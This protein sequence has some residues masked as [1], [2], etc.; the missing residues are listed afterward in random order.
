MD[1]PCITIVMPSYNQASYLEEAICSVL[2]QNYPN[3]EFMILDAGSTDGS[4]TIIER[5]AHALSY[6]RSAPDDGQSAAI[7]EG[8]GR[9]TGDLA[10]WLN[11]DDVLLPGSFQVLAQA[12]CEHP[13]AGLFAG[14]LAFIDAQGLIT[15]FLRMPAQAEWFARRG[16]F[17][18]SG[19]GSLFRTADYRAAGGVRHDLH[20][21]MDNELYLRMMLRGTRCA[22]IDRYLAGFRR[23][24][25]QKTSAFKDRVQQ[26][27]MWLDQELRTKYNIPYNSARA[28][29]GYYFWQTLNGN[30]LKKRVHLLSARGRL[31][32]E[33][34]TAVMH[35]GVCQ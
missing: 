29:A 12:Y 26:E 2:D 1:Y 4:R 25:Q 13:T 32:R 28:R 3:L 33:W 34:A 20:Y 15:G 30:Y 18:V 35:A 8:L 21:V 19:P 24:R 9:S 17:A 5:Y 6:W 16:V 27:S 22:Y 31:W 14:N 11:S 23:H 10:G 7:D